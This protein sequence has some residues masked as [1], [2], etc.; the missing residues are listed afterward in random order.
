[1][2]GEKN[3]KHF[4]S[5]SSPVHFVAKCTSKNTSKSYQCL[6]SKMAMV[7]AGQDE[8]GWV[9]YKTRGVRNEKRS[10]CTILGG[11]DESWDL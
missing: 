3:V 9:Y 11:V 2:A 10:T 6:S 8:D 4:L 1:M 7:A 5:F